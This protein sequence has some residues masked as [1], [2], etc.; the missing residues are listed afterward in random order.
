MN[1]TEFARKHV[2]KDMKRR[3][4]WTGLLLIVIALVILEAISHVQAYYAKDGIR[5]EAK[6]KA[7]GQ[8]NAVRSGILNVVNQAE[9]AVRN[10]VWLAQWCL[11]VPDSLA[12]IPKLIVN[13]N[14]II[15]GSTIA[16][17]P[18][19]YKNRPLYSPYTAITNGEI[20]ET[21]LATP[22]YDYP[23]KEWFTKPIELDREYWS[24][25]YIDTGGG[26]IL[27]TTFSVPI[28]DNQGRIAAVL[29]A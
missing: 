26:E 6:A 4:R 28:K 5:Q 8:L 18:N 19:Y 29:T 14:P 3:S 16:I 15:A 11:Q 7:E 13:N 24:E 1:I 27:M 17:V 2:E 23:S 9:S 25:P 21:S 12:N 10:N 20:I 22:E